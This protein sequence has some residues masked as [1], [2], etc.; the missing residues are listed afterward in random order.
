MPS[1]LTEQDFKELLKYKHFQFRGREK[2][3][4]DCFGFFLE[5][6]KRMGQEVPDYAYDEKN[7]G[8]LLLREY[9]KYFKKVEKPI[10]GDAILFKTDVIHIGV[11][12]GEGRF[13]HL[14][15]TDGAVTTSLK[16]KPWCDSVRGYFRYLNGES[17]I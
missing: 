11:Y 5:C 2:G 13:L 1:K 6:C 4:I 12:I 17:N 14:S 8:R 3:G 16:S 9:H 10:P 15:R 7:A